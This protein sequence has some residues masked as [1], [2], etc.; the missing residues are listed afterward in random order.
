MTDGEYKALQRGEISKELSDKLENYI[1]ESA[2]KELFD[3]MRKS[4]VN[5]GLDSSI[6]TLNE[7]SI[8]SCI[9][10]SSDEW[11]CFKQSA[12]DLH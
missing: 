6:I 7:E 10:N 1:R 8:K 4:A 9:D 11:E 12:S 5:H 2:F 3:G